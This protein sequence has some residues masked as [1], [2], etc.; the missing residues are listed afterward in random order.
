MGE[1]KV[2]KQGLYYRF[3]CQCRLSGEVVC[4]LV[5]ENGD[6]QENLG[7]PMPKDGEFALER[8]IP[9]SHFPPGQWHIRVKPRHPEGTFVPLGPEEPFAYIS[10]LKNAH[11][12]R[13]N[14]VLGIVL[15]RRD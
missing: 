7:I 13:R 11:L 3:S 12:E 6:R 1:A 10:R 15:E 9:A 8:R 5:A 14:G 4:R 2:E